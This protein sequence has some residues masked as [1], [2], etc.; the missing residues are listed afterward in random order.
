M[1]FF[2]KRKNYLESK[3]AVED[4]ADQLRKAKETGPEV[5]RVSGELKAIRKKN[6]FADQL[7]VIMGGNVK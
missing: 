5:Q 6:H 1:R 3:Q 7:L 2:R 4:S